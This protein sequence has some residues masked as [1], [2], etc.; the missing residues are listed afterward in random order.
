M[1]SKNIILLIL[2]LFIIATA[3][4]IVVRDKDINEFAG[5]STTK[6]IENSDFGFEVTEVATKLE[7]PWDIDFL[8]NDRLIITEKINKLSIIESGKKIEVTP[9]Q[10]TYVNGEG[11][12]LA[13]TLDPEYSENNY[14]YLCFNAKTDGNAAE[15]FVSRFELNE[16]AKNLENR[17]NIIEGIPANESGRHSGCRLEFGP[18]GYLW[19][20]TGDTA[21]QKE[22]QDP[23]SLGGKILRV[24]RDGN[25][26]PDNLGENFDPRIYSYGHRN[27][28]GLSF[29]TNTEYKNLLGISI[30]HG[31]DRDD[32]V[33]LLKKGNFGWD[34]LPY[35]GEAVPMTDLEKFPDAIEALWSSGFPTTAASGGTIINSD[36]WGAWKNSIAVA[37]LKGSHL[38][39]INITPEGKI[40]ETERLFH[41]EYGRLRTVQEGPDGA[42]YILTDNGYGKDKVLKLTPTK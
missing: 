27:I 9:P 22:P 34:P 30:E 29:F 41:N 5:P 31:P 37:N 12:L 40:T 39:I 33:N 21:V 13:I 14:I 17:V 28:Q 25:P 4:A 2:I 15:M 6:K 23:T 16:D 20:A 3:S 26:A 24:D 10:D 35:Y 42:L 1:K 32:E 19:V 38:L 8:S 11:G 36:K 7:K 18:D